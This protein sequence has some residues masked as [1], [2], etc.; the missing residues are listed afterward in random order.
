MSVVSG[1]DRLE[2]TLAEAG[3][4]RVA[5]VLHGG[6][7]PLTVAP[8]TAYL[9]QT[10]H[11][12]TPTHPGWN[13][14]PRPEWLTGIDD[15]A[16]IYLRLLRDRGYRDV[17][18]VGSS[19]GGW[20]AAEMAV[21][22]TA[23]LIGRVVIID[24][25]GIVVP[26][27]PAADFFSLTPRGVAEHAYHDPDKFYV[28]PASVL[29]ERMAAQG[30]NMATLALIAGEPDGRLLRRLA[31]VEA[32]ALVLWGESDR[33]VTPAYGQAYAAALPHGRFELIERAGHLPQLE[34]PAATFAAI[35]R[36]VAA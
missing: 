16:M 28:D 18:V 24:G 2:L 13:G 26:D 32:P 36:F 5:L 15:L 4:G 22:D 21:R 25:T 9:S 12:M 34:Q 23:G 30:A 1:F 11:T 17:T 14:A 19:I 6:G 31:L 27:A 3:E 33:V 35:D 29:P 10:M 7:G 8:I 20:I